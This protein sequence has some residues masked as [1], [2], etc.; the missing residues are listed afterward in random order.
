M[1]LR[2]CGASASE[3]REFKENREK[4]FWENCENFARVFP[5]SHKSER[6]D[7]YAVKVFWEFREKWERNY[8][9]E[10]T[11]VRKCMVQSFMSGRQKFVVVIVK[12]NRVATCFAIILLF[13]F[14]L[15]FA[16][17]HDVHPS[18]T[19]IETRALIFK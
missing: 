13:R 4:M 18:H 11:V 16:E 3:V 6:R 7:E 12:L 14:S 17:K 9:G 10:M 15:E 19:L 2:Q 5:G 1:S 8:V